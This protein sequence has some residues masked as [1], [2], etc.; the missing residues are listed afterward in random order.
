MEEAPHLNRAD[1][2]SGLFS[3]GGS[4][5]SGKYQRGRK[6]RPK[7]LTFSIRLQLRRLMDALNPVLI[8]AFMG[9][10]SFC[11]GLKMGQQ[12]KKKIKISREQ[13]FLIFSQL[14]VCLIYYTSC[15]QINSCVS[16]YLWHCY[17]NNFVEFPMEK[18]SWLVNCWKIVYWAGR[19]PIKPHVQ[20]VLRRWKL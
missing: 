13:I 3:E 17:N 4:E 1:P 5:M 16:P 10:T 12:N 9:L 7:Q 6:L 2:I 8:S 20:L 15:K 18:L 14:S 11:Q 19:L